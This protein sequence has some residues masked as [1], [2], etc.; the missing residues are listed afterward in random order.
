MSR[1]IFAT[2][3]IFDDNI[4][5]PPPNVS[6]IKTPHFNYQTAHLIFLLLKIATDGAAANYKK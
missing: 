2:Y 4:Q 5:V 3:V 1:D 6:R